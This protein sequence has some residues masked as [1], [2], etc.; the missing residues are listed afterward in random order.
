MICT[1]RKHFKK[2]IHLLRKEK[3]TGMLKP[4]L[5]FKHLFVSFVMSCF[6]YFYEKISGMEFSKKVFAGNLKE[7][8]GVA[9]FS[10]ASF[11]RFSRARQIQKLLQ[12]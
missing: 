9:F 2:T 5:L 3:L 8:I 1:K 11:H 4:N 6:F 10:F 7:R 12:L